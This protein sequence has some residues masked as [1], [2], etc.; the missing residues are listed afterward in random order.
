MIDWTD[1]IVCFCETDTQGRAHVTMEA[2][3]GVMDTQA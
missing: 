2:E 3:L 1:T